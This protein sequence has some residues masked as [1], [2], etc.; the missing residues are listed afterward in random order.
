MAWREDT[1]RGYAGLIQGGYT[2]VTIVEEVW[3][4]VVDLIGRLGPDAKQSAPEKHAQE[5]TL[6]MIQVVHTE[7]WD[8]SHRTGVHLQ[9]ECL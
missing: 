2:V 4:V 8:L 9:S 6:Q 3:L 5:Q 1:I 7:V